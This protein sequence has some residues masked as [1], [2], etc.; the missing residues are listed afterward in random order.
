MF[1]NSF[2]S[3]L[4]VILISAFISKSA[5][6]FPVVIENHTIAA[7]DLGIEKLFFD[8]SDKSSVEYRRELSKNRHIQY[9]Q[10]TGLSRN[11]SLPLFERQYLNDI[12][13]YSAQCNLGICCEVNGARAPP[14]S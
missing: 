4:F 8:F 10:L 12:L 6:L 5:F 11:D 14:I 2:F 3:H 9:F 13:T 1:V 7:S